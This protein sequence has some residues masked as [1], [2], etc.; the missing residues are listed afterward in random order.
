[1]KYSKRTDHQIILDNMVEI[2]F[3]DD[4]EDGFRKVKETLERMGLPN[5]ARNTL[6][7]SCHIFHKQGKYYICHFL[8]LFALD[9]RE[10][11]LSEGDI[12]RRN[13][14]VKYL[15]DWNLIKPIT[16]NWVTPMSSPRSLKVLKH[17]DKDKWSLVS[18]YEVGVKK[19]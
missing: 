9:G 17:S 11:E 4:V 6:T 12:G 5:A 13:I 8:E 16:P 18:K 19:Y 10:V 14:I 1:M 15:I 7:Q 3:V 2:N